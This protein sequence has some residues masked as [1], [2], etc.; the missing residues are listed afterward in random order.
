MSQPDLNSE[1]IQDEIIAE[2]RA[3]R[4]SMAAEFGYDVELLFD[5]VKRREQM[6]ARPKLA[7]APKLLS[8]VSRP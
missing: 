4:D 2:V 8:A 5:E 6:S 1:P 7:P 3:I